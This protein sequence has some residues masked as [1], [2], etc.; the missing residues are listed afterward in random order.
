MLDISYLAIYALCSLVTG[1]VVVLSSIVLTCRRYHPVA[2]YG[3]TTVILFLIAVHG[4]VHAQSVSLVFSRPTKSNQVTL[5]CRDGSFQ[6]LTTANFWLNS[7]LLT[8][9]LSPS[10]YTVLANG[11]IRFTIRWDLE[12]FYS[13]GR[14]TRESNTLELV[15]KGG[16]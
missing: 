13:C 12:G 14:S 3:I 10:E 2:M 16:Y 15:G 6:Q 11:M 7:S 1:A 9:L 5:T 8:S 4:S